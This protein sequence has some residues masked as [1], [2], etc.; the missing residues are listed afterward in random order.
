MRQWNFNNLQHAASDE[1]TIQLQAQRDAA[2]VG[3]DDRMQMH[4]VFIA[5][6]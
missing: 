3:N 6:A 4:H 5:L 1:Q 2:H